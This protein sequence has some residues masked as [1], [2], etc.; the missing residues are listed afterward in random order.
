MPI[1]IAIADD[2]IL[3]AKALTSIINKIGP[4]EVL[5]EV[6]NG[7]EL[8]ERFKVKTNIPDIVLLDVSMPLMNGFETAAWLKE[9]YPEVFI[10]ALSMQDDENSLI[11]MIRSGAH[12]YLLKD[13]QPKEL[14]EALQT[15][16][17]NG[18]YYP[19]WA[20]AKLL[21]NI[22]GDNEPKLT[23]EFTERE[24][25][26]MKYVC[27]EMSWKEIA[28]KMYCSPRTVESYRDSLFEKLNLKSRV[29]LAVYAMKN[30]FA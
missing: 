24:T 11:K 22:Q 30:G 17:K 27:T 29:G 20:T 5:Y 26:L 2:H 1:T 16:L 25:E 6:E 3:I 18:F 28:E 19:G 7:K 10:M 21:R 14:H 15:M 13:I 4:Y 12:G 9:K 23:V 8:I